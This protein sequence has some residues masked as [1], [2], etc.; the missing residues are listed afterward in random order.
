MIGEWRRFLPRKRR[1]DV[2]DCVRHIVTHAFKNVPFYRRVYQNAGVNPAS[3]RGTA[4]LPRLPIIQRVDL[5]SGGPAEYLRGDIAPERLTVRHTTGTTGTPVAIYM[6]KMEEA[7]RRLTLMD[8]FRR[9][10]GLTLPMTIVD[11][12]CERKDHATKVIKRMGPVTIVRLFRTLPSD[13][14]IKILMSV[15]PTIIGGRPSAFW[16]LANA[17]REQTI[18]PPA[19]RLIVSG[20]ELLFPHVRNLL[21]DVFRCR[22]AD[23]YNCEEAGNLAWQ[24]PAHPDRM[25]PNT[26]TVWIEAV[27]PGGRPVAAGEEGRLIITNLYNYSSPFIRYEMGDRGTLLEPEDCSCGFKGPVMRLTEGR[28]ENFIILPD[29][30]EISPRLMYEVVNSAFPHEK[31]GWSMIDAILVFQIIQEK[32]D[33]IVLKIVPGAAYSD[34]LLIPVEENIKRLHPQMRLKAEIVADLRPAPGKKFHQ[35]WGKLNS[36]WQIEHDNYPVG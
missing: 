24:C 9:N 12:G 4:D 5:M 29:G 31:P 32:T 14:K 20:A 35:V 8:C 17:L 26:A 11:V 30:R 3:I 10:N 34:S 19:P 33:L 36:R 16:E 23:N 18:E 21:E 25:H 2:D 7:F 22:V 15:R 13:E 1:K 6:N 28:T 27:D